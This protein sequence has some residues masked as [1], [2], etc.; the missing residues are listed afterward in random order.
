MLGREPTHVI[1]ADLVAHLRDE[2]RLIAE[3]AR[4]QASL[5]EIVPGPSSD[6]L[7]VESLSFLS[8]PDTAR[9]TL[10]RALD[11]EIDTN[12]RRT[13]IRIAG[14]TLELAAEEARA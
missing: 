6:R 11:L 5:A 12:V 3:I 1:A 13:A 9:T 4:A 14:H 10:G 7:A 8:F 2:R